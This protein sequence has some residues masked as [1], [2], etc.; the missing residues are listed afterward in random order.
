M[1]GT[2]LTNNTVA[3]PPANAGEKA[4]G[5]T[6]PDI[7]TAAEQISI[8]PLEQLRDFTNHGGYQDARV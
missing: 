6:A 5:T 1:K 2:N 3:A 4:S 8:V 7:I